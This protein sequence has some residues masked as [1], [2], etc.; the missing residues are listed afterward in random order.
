[1]PSVLIEL[2]YISTHDEE[3]FL[4][5]Q[6]GIRKMSQSIYNA[7]LSYKRQHTK[8][9]TTGAE[10]DVLQAESDETQAVEGAV[11]DTPESDIGVLTQNSD[12]PSTSEPEGEKA[13]TTGHGLPA[14]IQNTNPGF[15][16]T[17]SCG[18]F[19]FQKPFSDRFL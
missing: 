6:N 7:F 18:Q 3:A 11:T 2:G 17:D 12:K 15:H 4:N 14:C 1:M 16:P 9:K 8:G 10:K 5:S 13:G 19:P